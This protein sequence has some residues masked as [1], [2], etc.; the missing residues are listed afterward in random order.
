MSRHISGEEPAMRVKSRK[1]LAAYWN[2]SSACG[3]LAMS[4]TSA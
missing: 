4:S 2:S 1:P 3:F